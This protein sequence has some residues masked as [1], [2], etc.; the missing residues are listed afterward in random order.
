MRLGRIFLIFVALTPSTFAASNRVFV[1]SSGMDVGT[2]LITA[3]CR[4]FNYA[5]SQV[6]ASGEVI[7]IDTAGY[8]VFTISQPVNVFAAPGVTAFIAVTGGTGITVAAG[9]SDVV[10]LRGLALTG[11]GG[12]IGVDFQSGV[13][14]SLENCVING[15]ANQGVRAARTNDL[16]NPRL[17]I[18]HSTIR[19]TTIGSGVLTRNTGAGMPPP[20]SIFLTIAHSSIAENHGDGL[21]AGDNTHGVVTDTVFSGNHFGAQVGTSADNS[22]PAVNFE[23]C[24][25]SQNDTAITAGSGGIQVMIRGTAR[26]AHNI[27][28]GNS[29]ALLE[30]LDGSIM[31]MTSMGIVTNTIEGNGGLGTFSGSY[32]A[33]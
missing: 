33:K 3:P 13:S 10:V 28:T 19:E 11:V 9:S 1:K 29:L 21:T 17:R 18:E 4:S 25:F 12:S 14:L 6:L 24:A 7:A 2:C 26:I 15:F 20:Y 31:T 8:G 32:T 5:M 22:A 30:Y 16:S 23:R 27:I